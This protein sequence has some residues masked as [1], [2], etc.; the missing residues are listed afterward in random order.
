MRIISENYA[1][2]LT[3]TPSNVDASYPI[4]NVQDQRL[5]VKFHSTTTSV[6]ITVNSTAVELEPLAIAI[7]GH[8]L[9]SSATILFQL[10]EFSDFSTVASQI[11]TWDDEIILKFIDESSMPAELLT[12][13]GDELLTETGDELW[14][15]F[16]YI[17][18]RFYIDDPTNSDGYISIGRLWVGPYLDISPSSL[19]DFAVTLKNS[20][21][22]IYGKDRQKFSLP[23]VVWRKF[24][25]SFPPTEIAMIDEIL[26][27]IDRV[28][29]HSS[30]IFC[31]FDTI[32]DYEIVEPCYVSI[33]GD[34][35][36]THERRMKWKYSLQLEEDL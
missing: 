20:D 14:Q 8:N 3:L 23:G 33:T 26:D 28:G 4:T 24:D 2:S 1:D 19:L 31:N 27:L 21:I 16:N 9:T 32:R 13:T 36:F 29:Y 35:N 34:V 22:N 6:Y 17:Y 15:W 25:L 11:M 30:F 5:S 18:N 7:L 12:E 10:S